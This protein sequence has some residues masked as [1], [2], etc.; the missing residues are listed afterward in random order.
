MIEEKKDRAISIRL[1]SDEME[2]L[3]QLQK[4]TGQKSKSALIRAILDKALDN[5]APPWI[6]HEINERICFIRAVID[7]L[8][9]FKETIIRDLDEIS[10]LIDGQCDEEQ[11]KERD[12]THD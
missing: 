7:D 5:R 2:K 8:S 1:T 10:E 3:A 9:C 4:K 12:D 11:S 6:L